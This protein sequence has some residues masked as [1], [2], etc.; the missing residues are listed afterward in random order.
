MGLELANSHWQVHQSFGLLVF[1]SH[2]EKFPSRGIGR[3]KA[4]GWGE[5][6]KAKYVE[7]ADLWLERQA[8]NPYRKVWYNPEHGYFKL[9]G[10][11]SNGFRPIKWL[12]AAFAATG[13]TRYRDGA[14]LGVNWM[15]GGN[16][17]GRPF[18]TG[19]G[20]TPMT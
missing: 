18:T 10:W 4:L 13:D 17:L 15:H 8:R 16:P 5:A 20:H 3:S 6:C 11:G 1:A 12:T 9:M 2:P 7:Q 19:L 14:L